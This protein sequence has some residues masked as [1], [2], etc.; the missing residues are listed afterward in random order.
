MYLKIGG[1]ELFVDYEQLNIMLTTG[2]PSLK[3]GDLSESETEEIFD[4]EGK[5]V[6]K[7]ITTK[8]F[9][10][11]REV[12]S[13]RY[14]MLMEMLQTVMDVE[15]EADSLGNISTESFSVGQRIAYNTLIEYKILNTIE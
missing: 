3:G 1:E 5:L 2:D 10:K 6:S 15:G 11:S 14:Q 7:K 8:K 12:D 13:F 9:V 4:E